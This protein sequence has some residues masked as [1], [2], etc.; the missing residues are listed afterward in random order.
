MNRDDRS[1]SLFL[2]L[3]LIESK[4]EERFRVKTQQTLHGSPLM[5]PKHALRCTFS[6]S[7]RHESEQKR[8]RDETGRFADFAIAG[9]VDL[10]PANCIGSYTPVV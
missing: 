4:L 9:S 1:D 3:S 10:A 2:L 7:S 6:G 5:R 8:G